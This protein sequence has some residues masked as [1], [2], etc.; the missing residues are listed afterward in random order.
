[1]SYKVFEQKISIYV[2]NIE[3]GYIEYNKNEN[4]IEIMK[5][6]IFPGY[7]ENGYAQSLI[8]YVVDNYDE[9]V[10]KINCSY[11]RIMAGDYK[12]SLI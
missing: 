3:A 4:G 1:M 5:T 9:K 8:K 10:N 12:L 6:Y 7:R 2:G 11:Y